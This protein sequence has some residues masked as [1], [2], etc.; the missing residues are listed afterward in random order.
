MT[1]KA[2]EF[3]DDSFDRL[4]ELTQ[5]GFSEKKIRGAV[6]TV[7]NQVARDTI[8]PT[9]K[10]VQD[11]VNLKQKTIKQSIKVTKKAKRGS[12]SAIISIVK[13]PRPGLK[14]F[15]L[16]AIKR[17]KRPAGIKYQIR[18]GKPRTLAKGFIIEKFGGHAFIN[19]GGR[20]IAKL[21][22]VSVFGAV[23][24]NDIHEQTEID[25]ME[26]LDYRINRFIR[27]QVRKYKLK[28]EQSGT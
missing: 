21:H 1:V 28:L 3:A 25:V 17:G 20:K 27:D 24:K 16:K 14:E 12:L 7:I 10:R 19:V 2:I 18:P 26:R 15:K 8:K 5:I 4:Q 13:G 22:G 9:A 23:A 11:V 6:Y